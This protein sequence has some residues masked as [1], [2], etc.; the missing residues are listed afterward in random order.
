MDSDSEDPSPIEVLVVFHSFAGGLL[1]G[2]IG[3]PIGIII[4][5]RDI[6]YFK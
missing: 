6:Y 4:G 2:L 1:G 3:T 5:K